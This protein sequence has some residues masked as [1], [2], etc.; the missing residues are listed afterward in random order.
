[1]LEESDKGISDRNHKW[2]DFTWTG[3]DETSWQK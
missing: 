2:V 1:M 3:V